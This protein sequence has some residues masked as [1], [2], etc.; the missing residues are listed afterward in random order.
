MAWLR[1]NIE[2]NFRPVPTAFVFRMPSPWLFGSTAHYVVTS[3]QKTDIVA[4][5]SSLRR[6][7]SLSVL[8]LLLWGAAAAG[9]TWAFAGMKFLVFIWMIKGA[10]VASIALIILIDLRLKLRRIKPILRSHLRTDE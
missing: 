6:V 8:L 7:L 3:M 1:K 2:A 10:A 5:M 4:V 9:A